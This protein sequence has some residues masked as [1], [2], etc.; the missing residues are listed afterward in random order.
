MSI[1]GGISN[2]HFFFCCT[3]EK[4]AKYFKFSKT[5]NLKVTKGVLEVGI[6]LN[7]F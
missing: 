4:L 6:W 2:M 7:V 3:H 5:S 1:F